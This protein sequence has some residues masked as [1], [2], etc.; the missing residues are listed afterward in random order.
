[1]ETHNYNDVVYETLRVSNSYVMM[2]VLTS[3]PVFLLRAI[4]LQADGM[5]LLQNLLANIEEAKPCPN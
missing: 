5:K 3:N 1:M 4:E 2:Y